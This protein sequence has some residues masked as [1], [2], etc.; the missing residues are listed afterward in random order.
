MKNIPKSIESLI[1]ERPILEHS[2]RGLPDLGKHLISDNFSPEVK[3]IYDAFAVYG[4][5]LYQ[6]EKERIKNM[7]TRSLG[8]GS[9]MKTSVFPPCKTEIMNYLAYNDLSEYPL[10]AGD[11]DSRKEILKYLRKEGFKSNRGLDIDN[12]IFTV[13]STQAFNIILN[14]ISRP[15]DVILMTG[16]NYGLFTFAPER[17]SGANV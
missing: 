1:K 14:I 6:L 2:K 12:I 7:E 5:E 9:P 17:V 3:K 11:E 10:A 13:S 16:P 8:G 4:N 15:N